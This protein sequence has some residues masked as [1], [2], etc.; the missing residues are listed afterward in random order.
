[1]NTV[2][3]PATWGYYL[4]QIVTGA[5]PSPDTILPLARDHFSA[6]VRARGHFPIL[7][8]GTQPYGVLPVTWS[9]QWKSLEGRALDTPLMGLLAQMRTTWERSVANVPQL[10]GAADPEAVLVRLLGMTPSS[11]S[12]AARS[13]IGPEYNLSYWRFIQQDPGEAWWTALTTKSLAQTGTLSA[14]LATTR[15]AS[16]TFANGQ[17]LLTEVLVAPAPLDGLP[18]PAYIEQLGQL[19]WQ[20]LRDF[21]TPPQP[22]PLLLLLLRHAALRQYLDTAGDLLETAGAAQP[23]ER[24]GSGAARLVSGS[25]TSDAVGSFATAAG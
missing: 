15:L 20:A 7:R 21:V 17:R 24:D 11:A 9:A 23:S 18:S 3:W 5:V 16:S 13:V 8:V 12:F 19:T 10:H 22:V 25:S 2:L 6:H 1:M 4:E 14:A